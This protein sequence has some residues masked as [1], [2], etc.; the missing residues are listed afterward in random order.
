M[1]NPE[2]FASQNVFDV[3]YENQLSP[4]GDKIDVTSSKRALDRISSK[5][6]IVLHNKSKSAYN[7]ISRQYQRK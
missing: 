1:K 6:S 4:K 5:S 2:L 3:K 7:T